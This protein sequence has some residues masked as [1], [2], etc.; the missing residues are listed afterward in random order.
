[1]DEAYVVLRVGFV[2]YPPSFNMGGTGGGIAFITAKSSKKFARGIDLSPTS[3]LLI[4][5]SLIIGTME[6]VRDEAA[7]ENAAQRHRTTSVGA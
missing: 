2:H 7:H 5:E 6:V 3:E 4:D 1:M